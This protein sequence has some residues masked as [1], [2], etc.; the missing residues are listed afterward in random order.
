MLEHTEFCCPA[1]AEGSSGHLIC[2][3]C[4]VHDA[5]A[6][7]VL[8]EDSCVIRKTK[9]DICKCGHIFEEATE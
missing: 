7:S 9:C 4:D 6:H 5:K 1:T 2:V 3:R 8:F